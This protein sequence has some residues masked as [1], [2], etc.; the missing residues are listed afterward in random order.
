M[1]RPVQ[2]AE[3]QES[4]TSP[5]IA[6]ATK[7]DSTLLSSS[8]LC[9]SLISSTLLFYFSLLFSIILYSTLLYSSLLFSTLLYSSLL[10]STLL[11][12][13]LVFSTLLYSLIFKTPQL[14]S[15]SSKLPLRSVCIAAP[16]KSSTFD[17][18][19]ET[20]M[21]GRRI[22]AFTLFFHLL[23]ETDPILLYTR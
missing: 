5:N 15:F 21:V 22:C 8:L 11:Y 10:F 4:P 12:S 17:A 16:P 13:S 23:D 20:Y 6:P 18:L 14:G 1:K 3:Q 9:S 19:L 2:Y 7:N